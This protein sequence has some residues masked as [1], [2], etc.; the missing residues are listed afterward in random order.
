M[1]GTRSAGTGS[2]FDNPRPGRDSDAALRRQ[3]PHRS[4]GRFFARA[5]LC[6]AAAMAAAACPNGGGGGGRS[7]LVVL[8]VEHDVAGGDSDDAG[9]D[10]TLD[11]SGRIIVMG[12]S[13]DTGWNW[14]MVIWS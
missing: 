13:I 4:D 14:D 6:L 1:G 7:R 12:G 3:V 2:V 11:G 5:I 9:G 10:I 8:D